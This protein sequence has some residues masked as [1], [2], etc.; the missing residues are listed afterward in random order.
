MEDRDDGPVEGVEV[1]AGRDL[2]ARHG[3]HL[4]ELAA[5]EG[6]APDGEDEEEDG[7]EEKEGEGVGGG[8]GHVEEHAA[9][10]G[11]V[12]RE[13]ED[14]QE[15]HAAQGVGLG[16]LGAEEELE[17]GDDHHEQVHAVHPVRLVAPPA[18][19]PHL[20]ERLQGEDQHHDV[21]EPPQE[22]RLAGG[23]AVVR[24]GEEDRAAQR[25]EV[26]EVVEHRRA[27]QR[28]A[29]V[30]AGRLLVRHAHGVLA[31]AARPMTVAVPEQP[32]LR[33]LP[34]AAAGSAAIGV[35]PLRI[36]VRVLPPAARALRQPEVP[37]AQRVLRGQLQV[38]QR[39][40]EQERDLGD[41]AADG[42]VRR[43]LRLRLRVGGCRGVLADG[44]LG[45]SRHRRRRACSGVGQQLQLGTRLCGVW[46]GS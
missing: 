6:H 17:E 30:R 35:L 41:A 37:R 4:L 27:G 25:H 12:L 26:H 39:A 15:A 36:R 34:R 24:H 40:L 38:A 11:P 18:K 32:L 10:G 45:V 3:V 46:G 28:R 7:G 19:A 20:D 31:P 21:V 9:E 22:R 29:D 16:A 42:A 8:E 14:A 1:G 13:R 44:R 5:E 43:R 23:H 33:A 2:E